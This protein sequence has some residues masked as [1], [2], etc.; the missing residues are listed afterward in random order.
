MNARLSISNLNIRRSKKYSPIIGGVKRYFRPP[1]FHIG[2]SLT[3]LPLP[4]STPMMRPST[5]YCDTTPTVAS[6]YL[7]YCD[8]RGIFNLMRPS[9]DQSVTE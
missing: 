9:S 4:L 7:I 6:S 8:C 1:T 3:T 2:G 5:L